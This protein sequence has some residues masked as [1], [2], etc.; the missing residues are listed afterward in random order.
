MLGAT[1]RLHDNLPFCLVCT[2]KS[3]V[4][5]VISHSSIFNLAA[6]DIDTFDKLPAHPVYKVQLL[7]AT[8]LLPCPSLPA[9][10]RLG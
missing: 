7:F 5:H 1:I 4:P 6:N 2:R 10:G 9:L 3:E 8:P